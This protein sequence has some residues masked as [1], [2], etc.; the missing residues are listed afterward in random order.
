MKHPSVPCEVSPS[1]TEPTTPS[2]EATFYEQV[3]ALEREGNAFVLIV[4]VD[5]LGSTP[6]TRGPRC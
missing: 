6:R 5:A 4:L 1:D 3:V 2:P